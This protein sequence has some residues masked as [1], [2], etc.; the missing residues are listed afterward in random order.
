MSLA[1][2]ILYRSLLIIPTILI[3]Y[4]I[5]FIVLRILPGDPVLAVLGTKN[6]PPEQLESIRRSLGLDKPLYVQYFEYLYRFIRGD[7]G[8]SLIIQGRPIALDI[9]ERLPATIELSI[10]SILVALLIG[11]S[12]GIV[13]GRSS[14]TLVSAFSRIFGS[15]TYAIFIPWFGMLLQIVFGIWLGVLPVDGRTSPGVIIR[16]PTGLYIIDSIINR[17]PYALVDSIRHI[18]LPSIT[19][20]VVL[21]GPYM[22]LVRN[23]MRSM[24]NSKIVLAYRS[25]GISESRISRHVLRHV[26]IPVVTYS[27][28]QFALLLG[29][30]VLTET[31]FNWP[32]IGTYLVDKVFYRDYPAIQA[33]VIVFA[34]FVGVISLVVDILYS[35]IDPRIRY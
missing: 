27:G 34:F 22:R 12:I 23:N 3:L 10:A 15:F 18:I 28:L 6:I 2:Y 1:R 24:L 21:S 8:T 14:S 9:A 7:M 16:G 31:T 4:T 30:A 5:V 26:M 13:S 35:L 29:G 19:L 32:G 20:G 25:R 17:D 33:V 11:V